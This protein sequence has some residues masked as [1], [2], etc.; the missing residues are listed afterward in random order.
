MATAGNKSTQEHVLGGRVIVFSTR[1]IWSSRMG[2]PH[3]MLLLLLRSRAAWPQM[4]EVEGV[5][6]SSGAL[7]AG[8]QFFSQ[9]TL[10]KW[11]YRIVTECPSSAPPSTNQLCTHGCHPAEPS[12]ILRIEPTERPQIRSRWG[13]RV[14]KRCNRT[15]KAWK[16]DLT[17]HH[18]GSREGKLELVANLPSPWENGLKP[19]SMPLYVSRIQSKITWLMKNQENLT[20]HGKRQSADTNTKTTRYW[21]CLTENVN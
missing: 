10:G 15:A 3:Q 21:D 8:S 4:R 1:W 18:R 2:K 5:Q 6:S 14:W 17:M 11:H 13:T 19:H 12:N 7:R 9:R 20:F 16:P